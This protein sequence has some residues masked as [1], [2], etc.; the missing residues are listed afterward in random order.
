MTRTTV[1]RTTVT[2]SDAG[3][4]STELAILMPVVVL[5]ALVAVFLVQVQQHASR[6]QGAA[7]AAA[8]TASLFEAETV[9]MRVAAEAAAARNCQGAVSGF[10]ID[11]PADDQR[12]PLAAGFV[13][14]RLT[15]HAEFRGF[16]RLLASSSRSVD[17]V[18]VAAFEYWQES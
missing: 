10:D 1:T 16:S 5:I 2:R 14:I 13:T 11:W 18:G 12:D 7:D 3:L 9:E 6:A 17:A 4:M 15:C 8:R